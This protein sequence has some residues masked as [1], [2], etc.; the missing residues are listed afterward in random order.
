MSG[1]RAS[2]VLEQVETHVYEQLEHAVRDRP[3]HVCLTDTF[4]CRLG[5]RADVMGRGLRFLGGR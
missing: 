1:L 3:L 4:S 5:M 2:T